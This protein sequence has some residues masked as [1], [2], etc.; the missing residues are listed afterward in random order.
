LL[1]VR[2]R[3]SFFFFAFFA[4]ENFLVRTLSE[5]S[6]KLRSKNFWCVPFFKFQ[7]SCAGKVL[8]A[9]VR[10][11]TQEKFFVRMVWELGMGATGW[12]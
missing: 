8:C 7:K 2:I 6:E 5:A 1:R 12:G 4:Q 10:K 9:P 11:V 3:N